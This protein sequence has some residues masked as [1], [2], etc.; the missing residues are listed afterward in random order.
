ML[1]G[2][3]LVPN[4]TSIQRSSLWTQAL[5]E[6]SSTR[7]HARPPGPFGPNR[8]TLTNEGLPNALVESTNTKLCLLTRVVYRFKS[9]DNLVALCLLD[10]GGYCS[11]L[12]GGQD[13]A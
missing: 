9:N 7:V 8:Y 2:P 11:P 6:L 12:P 1:S 3:L 13:A 10:R 4:R 5:R